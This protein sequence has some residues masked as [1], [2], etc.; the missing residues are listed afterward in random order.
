MEILNKILW[1]FTIIA[2]LQFIGIGFYM[3]D[4]ENL[5]TIKKENKSKYNFF[6]VVGIISLIGILN[7]IIRFL[8]YYFK[9]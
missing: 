7:V 5:D 9:N 8:I 3:G 6:I 2:V 4:H 1:L